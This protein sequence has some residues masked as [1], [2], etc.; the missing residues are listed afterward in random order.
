MNAD[1]IFA[2]KVNRI[3]P[4]PAAGNGVSGRCEQWEQQ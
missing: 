4:V 2:N 3:V 1:L